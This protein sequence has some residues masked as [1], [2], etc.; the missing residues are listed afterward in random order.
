M[1]DILIRPT[2]AKDVDTLW[3]MLMYAAQES[4]LADVETNPDSARY[5]A[6]WGKDGDM[7]V[8]AEKNAVAVG[9]A[10]VRLW[11]DDNRGYGYIV[12][13]TPELAIAVIPKMRGKGIGT[14]LLAK[15]LELTQSQFP[16]ICLSTQTANPALRLYKRTGFV[17]VEGSE[18]MNQ[19]G[20]SSLTMLYRFK[21]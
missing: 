1:L 14:A 11:S 3:I 9:A 2:T 15:L 5:V 16:A 20:G 7:G 12:D 4:S 8:I 10:W 19:T 17:L 18:V 13:D 6:G 21:H